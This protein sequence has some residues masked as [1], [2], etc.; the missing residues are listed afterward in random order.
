MCSNDVYSGVIIGAT[1]SCFAS[2]DTIDCREYSYS[3]N[4]DAYA[5]RVVSRVELLDANQTVAY[6]DENVDT[7]TKTENDLSSGT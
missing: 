6:F 3:E 5:S 7:C 1:C 2:D 4:G